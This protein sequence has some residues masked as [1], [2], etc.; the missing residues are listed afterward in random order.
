MR[1]EEG[2][3]TPMSLSQAFEES[4]LKFTNT[5]ISTNEDEHGSID[6]DDDDIDLDDDANSVMQEGENTR[7]GIVLEA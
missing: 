5:T 6:G 3:T 4:V 1:H 7:S 2:D